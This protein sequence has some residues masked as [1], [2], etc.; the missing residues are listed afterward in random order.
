VIDTRTSFRPMRNGILGLAALTLLAVGA[1]AQDTHPSQG[2]TSGGAAPSA[3]A[4]KDNKSK[5][6]KKQAAEPAT[7]KLHITVVDPKGNP[8]DNASVYVR[9]NESGGFLKKDKLAELSF[10]TNQ[11]GALKVPEVPQGRV[12]VQVITK[13]WHTFGQWYDVDQAE[14]EIA[15]KLA[16]PVKWY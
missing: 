14:Q 2:G 16:P 9:Y 3:S 10:K 7:A 8:V 1:L 13:N 11:Q 6:D 4:S 12:M 15:I 5:D